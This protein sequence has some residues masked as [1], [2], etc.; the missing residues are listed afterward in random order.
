MNLEETVPASTYGYDVGTRHEHDRIITILEDAL[1][2]YIGCGCESCK[3]AAIDMKWT[4]ALI[5]GKRTWHNWS[6]LHALVIHKAL[7]FYLIPESH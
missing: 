7:F 4:I 1:S 6:L 3:D 2:D 5:K